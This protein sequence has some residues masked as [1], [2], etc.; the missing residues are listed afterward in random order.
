MIQIVDGPHREL[1][2]E[3]LF[4]LTNLSPGLTYIFKVW[5]I[6]MSSY[7]H[8]NVTTTYFSTFTKEPCTNTTELSLCYVKVSAAPSPTHSSSMFLSCILFNAALD[9]KFVVYAPLYLF[10]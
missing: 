7:D 8:E 9:F 6:A 10:Y 3:Y 2:L 4:I 1:T 5:C